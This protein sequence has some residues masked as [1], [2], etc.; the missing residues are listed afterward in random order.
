MRTS[1]SGG[2][3]GRRTRAPGSATVGRLRTPWLP[4]QRGGVR[5]VFFAAASVRPDDVPA[6]VPVPTRD[7][8]S[9]ASSPADVPPPEH[10]H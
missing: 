10:P 1:L 7:D 2:A 5:Y 3:A 6:G 9:Q 4:G 8:Q